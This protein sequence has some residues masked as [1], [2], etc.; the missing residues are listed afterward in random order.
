LRKIIEG[1]PFADVDLTKVHIGFMTRRPESM[2]LNL[3]PFLP[4]A[5]VVKGDEIYYYLPNGMA[6]T[7]LPGYVDRQLKVPT[8]VRNFN[9]TARLLALAWG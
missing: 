2:H 1:N 4:E 7:K 5:A 6:R 8:T 3:A 9:T